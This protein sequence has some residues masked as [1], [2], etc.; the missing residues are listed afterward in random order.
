VLARQTLFLIYNQL[1][2]SYDEDGLSS[3]RKTLVSP[4]LHKIEE[5][6]KSMEEVEC[7]RFIMSIALSGAITPSSLPS[8]PRKTVRICVPRIGSTL[9]VGTHCNDGRPITSSW[10]YKR[11]V[12]LGIPIVTIC[13]KE[14]KVVEEKK[15]SD[16]QLW[17]DKYRPQSLDQVIGHKAEIQQ[18][19]SWLQ[20]WENGI[21]THRGVL[22]TGPPG[23]GKTTTIHLLATSLGYSV[24][25]YNASD[26]RSIQTLRG[27]FLLGV[28]RLRK[29]IIVMDEV[30]GLSER[31][32]VGELATILRKTN[33][34]IFCIA[35]ERPPKL[36]PLQS[37]CAEVRFSR[38]MRSTIASAIESVAKKEGVNI[39]RMELETM[40]E[41]N[42]NDI[43]AILNQLSFYH[44][45]KGEDADKDTLHRMEPFS[46]TQRLFAQK[47]MSWNEATDLMFVDYHLIPLMIQEAYV[48]AGQ[49]D[50]QAISDAANA[51][52]MGD[53]MT[54]RVYQTQDWGLIPHVISQPICAVKTVSGRAPFQIFPQLL[55]KMSKQRKHARWMEDMARRITHGH[56]S[57]VMRLDYAE[58]LRR[59]LSM[60]LLQAKPEIHNVMEQME[61]MGVTRDDWFESLEET[62]F[63]SIVIP[64]KVK[65]AFTREWN[66]I[67]GSDSE[68]VKG[69]TKS[70]KGKS[71]DKV[72]DVKEEQEEDQEEQEEQEEQ[73][74]WEVEDAC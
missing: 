11:A 40:C 56:S 6:I 23:I 53:I 64:T 55:G 32:G 54:R 18:L 34:P 37:A 45:A 51:L 57:R 29:E 8:L 21:P 15:G 74:N 62:A 42:G 52:S 27:L 71:L 49:D 30:D 31:G 14:E 13:E 22:V 70:K 24:T 17:V 4:F 16:T 39:T 66:K 5:R 12:S 68:I 20:Q 58:P 72:Q 38:P 69:K 25:E 35:N 1:L 67:H 41:K 46:V 44:Q 19:R 73:D 48:Y 26:S 10:K 28:K 9:Y 50:M 61:S 3:K 7:K 65:T 60:G 36:K 63:E 43:R 47:R 2:C 59:S 33:T